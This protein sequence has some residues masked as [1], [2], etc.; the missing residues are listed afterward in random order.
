MRLVDLSKHQS[1]RCVRMMSRLGLGL[2]AILGSAAPFSSQDNPPNILKT[3]SAFLSFTGF[4]GIC[5]SCLLLREQ[6]SKRGVVLDPLGDRLVTNHDKYHHPSDEMAHH[7]I[8]PPD[9]APGY[10]SL[11]SVRYPL[12]AIESV[13]YSGHQLSIK[14]SRARLTK[15]GFYRLAF[16][17]MSACGLVLFFVTM[18]L[19]RPPAAAI[20]VTITVLGLA[21]GLGVYCWTFCVREMRLIESWLSLC[22]GTYWKRFEWRTAFIVILYKIS[23]ASVGASSAW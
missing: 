13:S 23:Q 1:S 5:L 14:I 3:L 16:L 20:A 18:M 6:Q 12:L 2:G 21:F 9:D 4:L 10:F 11:Y 17:V 19:Q 8:S 7:E 22:K 15:T